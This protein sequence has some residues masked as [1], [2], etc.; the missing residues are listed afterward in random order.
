VFTLERLFDPATGVD[1]MPF[2]GIRGAAAFD[3]ARWKE[4]ASPNGRTAGHPQRWLEPVALPGVKALGRHTVQIQLAK[5]DPTFLVRLSY[6]TTAIVPRDYVE[7]V[8]PRFATAPI[9]TGPYVLKDWSRGTRMRFERNV[10]HF[11]AGH[12]G[13]D[14]VE[15]LL[16]VDRF[17]QGILFERGEID[18]LCFMTDPDALRFKRDPKL[19]RLLRIAE[20]T[21]PTFIALNC[22]L[23]PF[24]NRLVRQAMNYVVDKEALAKVLLHRGVPALGPLPLVMSG[25]NQ[26]L[27]EYPYDPAKARALLAEAGFAKGFETTLWTDRDDPTWMNLALFVQQKLREVELTIHLKEVS[28]PML[29]DVSGRR[30]AV[31]MSVSDWAAAFDDP[32]ETLDSLLREKSITEEGS[33]NKAFYA[34]PRVDQLFL[35]TENELD[36]A[37]RLQLYHEIEQLV[38]EDAPW[39]FLIHLNTETAYQPCRPQKNGGRTQETVSSLNPW[40]SA[41]RAVVEP[42]LVIVAL[43]PA[44]PRC[45]AG[46]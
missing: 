4:A 41:E 36:P 17:T 8:G 11:R 3:E 5:P 22:E 35:A 24:T 39:I 31:P 15:V 25:F 18:F 26:G 21:S 34:N 19:R 9:G 44:T 20:A 16:N 45:F 28:S 14:G 7:R 13:P 12:P 29:L 27:P 6:G 33:M 42:A 30:R 2:R 43:H 46:W 40:F 23:P 38:V 10:H 1:S 32:K 37:R